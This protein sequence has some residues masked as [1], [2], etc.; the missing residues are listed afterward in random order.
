MHWLFLGK[1]TRWC[2][3]AA[4]LTSARFPGQ[5]EVRLGKNGDAFPYEPG[6]Q[7]PFS[8]ISYLS[9]WIIPAWMLDAADIAINFH[10]GSCHYPGIGCYNFA[11]YEGC[12]EFGAVCHHMAPKV[13]T[14]Q[15]IAESLF[16]VSPNDTVESLK[17]RTMIMMAAMLDD[18]LDHLEAD[19]PLPVS[20]RQWTRPA[21]RRTQL[22]DLCR[23]T[24]QMS[25]AERQRRILA[26]TYPG[27]PG[28]FMPTGTETIYYPVP[29]R[30][31][32]A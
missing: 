29:Q 10:P 22:N 4:A 1:T 23:L 15:V 12:E 16:R 13:D 2:E 17:L 6:V 21:F 19:R 26:T 5:V 3:D 11:L 14:G 32:I 28:P 7:K 24:P 9:P 31:P 20:P 30:Q 27:A 18:I 25:E 8:V